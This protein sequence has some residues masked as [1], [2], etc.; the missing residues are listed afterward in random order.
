MISY[1]IL[2]DQDDDGVGVSIS[3]AVVSAEWQIGLS[4][5]Q[6]VISTS[7]A[8]IVVW[9]GDFLANISAGRRLRIVSDDGDSERT[10]F[11]GTI[12][13]VQWVDAHHRR[14]IA[15]GWEEELRHNVVTLPIYGTT[16]AGTLVADTLRLTKLRHP[17]LAGMC[18]ID[19]TGHNLIDHVTIF[20]AEALATAIDQGKTDFVLMG[21][22]LES[23]AYHVLGNIAL[24]ED[25]RFFV[26]REGVA[27]FQDRHRRY[28]DSAVSATFVDDM[29]SITLTTPTPVSQV[30]I[31]I[32]P[33]SAG[34]SHTILWSMG[35]A[36]LLQ[37]RGVVQMNVTYQVDGQTVGALVVDALQALVHYRAN[38]RANGLGVDRTPY[39]HVR[40]AQVG[41]QQSTLEIRNGASFPIYVVFLEV[42]GTP[43]FRDAPMVATVGDANQSARYGTR[44]RRIDPPLLSDPTDAFYLAQTLFLRESR[45]G[46]R[47]STLTTSTRRHPILAL[48]LTVGDC[49]RVQVTSADHDAYYRIIGEQHQV[50]KGGAD[51][52]MTWILDH[53]DSRLFFRVDRDSLDGERILLPY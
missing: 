26:D 35:R 48:A 45:Q 38:A 4:D 27:H 41:H 16:N 23:D 51:H 25:G 19:E 14:I 9:V 53:D 43:L 13:T 6:A 39:L 22:A 34:A 21:D 5:A 1:A 11:T 8:E 28:D 47:L 30:Q 42:R 44:T 29:D 40:L 52:R 46:A 24:S 17:I 3:P 37:P 15:Y 18:F 32:T 50:N 49:I 36:L 12:D 2:I 7:R 31:G 10:H 20:P 33:R